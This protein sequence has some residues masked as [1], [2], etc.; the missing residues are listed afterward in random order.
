MK[1]AVKS[2]VDRRGNDQLTELN[3]ANVE[4]AAAAEAAGTEIIVSGQRYACDDSR[5]AALNAQF[6]FGLVN[7]ECANADEVRLAAFEAMEAGADSIRCPV[8]CDAVEAMAKEA[9]PVVGHIG[10]MPKRTHWTRRAARGKTVDDALAILN[11]ARRR[12]DTGGLC[13]RDGN[14]AACGRGGDFPADFARLDFRG[15]GRGLRCPVPDFGRDF[16][17][18]RR[19]CASSCPDVLEFSGRI[20]TTASGP[21]GCEFRVQVRCGFGVVSWRELT[22]LDLRRRSEQVRNCTGKLGLAEPW[23]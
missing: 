9:I 6:T 2:L 22:G 3:M 1:I 4:H 23:A 13:G 19:A 11:D 12:R 16:W 7:G 18:N 21:R 8:K 10:F 15:L 20:R 14:C 17:R 5:T